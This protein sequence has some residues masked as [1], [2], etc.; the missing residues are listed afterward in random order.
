MRYISINFSTISF[1]K[2]SCHISLKKIFFF[3]IHQFHSEYVIYKD[4][5]ESLLLCTQTST[6]HFPNQLFPSLGN[7]CGFP[8]PTFV[9]S[10]SLGTWYCSIRCS[11]QFYFLGKL[12]HA[13]ARETNISYSLI[14]SCNN[15]YDIIGVTF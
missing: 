12:K 1:I 5:Y 3:L 14:L 7:F 15:Y 2:W 10:V 4:F 6:V 9:A 11:S 13:Y 8:F